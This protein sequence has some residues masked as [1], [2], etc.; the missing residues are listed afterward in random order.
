M[1]SSRRRPWILPFAIAAFSS[2]ARR[3]PP[4]ARV[5]AP[6]LR[7]PSRSSSWR[8]SF[9][10]DRRSSS[11]PVLSAPCESVDVG[12][13]LAAAP[14]AAHVGHDHRAA[15]PVF[16]HKGR[17]ANPHGVLSRVIARINVVRLGP[18]P[19]I[20]RKPLGW[21]PSRLYGRRTARRWRCLRGPRALR[22]ALRLG[23]GRDQRKSR[24]K[25]PGYCHCPDTHFHA[26]P[27]LFFRSYGLRLP[28]Q[29]QLRRRAIFAGTGAQSG[30]LSHWKD[31]FRFPLFRVML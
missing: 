16:P 25:R 7:A 26:R 12:Q 6:V 1:A 10:A 17:V 13:C 24:R 18:V 15:R 23:S 3:S 19:G 21:P 9:M 5:W 2:P 30:S 14:D 28:L 11:A 20:D 4:K 29:R 22:C 31:F 27:E 8:S